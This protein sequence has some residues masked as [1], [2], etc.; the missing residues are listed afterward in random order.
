M[1]D[2][3]VYLG[4]DELEASEEMKKA[5]EFEMR[6]ANISAPKAE[7]RNTSLLYN[8]TTLGELTTGPN[9][10]ASW[11]K[12]VQDILTFGDSKVDVD[13]SEKIIVS[14]LQFY[15]NLSKVLA[16]FDDRTKANYMA[17]RVAGSS[18]TY[19]DKK[20][21]DI[22]QKYAKAKTGQEVASVDWKRCGS[23]VGFNSL[24]SSNFVFAVSSMYARK[25]FPQNDKKDVV[26]MTR[27]LRQAFEQIVEN[28]DWMDAATKQEARAKLDKMGQHIAYPDEFLDKN[29]V[30]EVF[31][32]LFISETDFLGNA[33]RITK[34]FYAYYAKQLREPVDP[35]DWREHKLVAV[36]NAF[37]NPALNNFEFPAGILQGTFYDSRVPK[38]LNF[39][40]IGFIIGHEITH[41]FDDQGRQRNAKGELVDWWKPETN[42]KFREK[43]QCVIWQYGNYTVKQINQNVNGVNTQGENIADNGGLKEAYLAYG[44]L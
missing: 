19:L 39:G 5:L 3:A 14:D 22:K 17:W 32:N 11:T 44:K 38:Y 24:G 8:P 33:I 6:L 26:E 4:A 29:K 9:L 34:H 10:P 36:V 25:Y 30:D 43:A 18:M 37:Y 21:R 16:E 41:G 40:G 31:D 13:A 2:T 20:A 12:Y 28:I 1:V 42:E 7:R 15:A 27:Y 35:N 23:S